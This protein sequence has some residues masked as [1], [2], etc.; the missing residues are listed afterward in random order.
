MVLEFREETLDISEISIE[1]LI[2]LSVEIE[3]IFFEFFL[4]N[5]SDFSNAI[6]QC[7]YLLLELLNLL[8]GAFE[9]SVDVAEDVLVLRVLLFIRFEF[10]EFLL[11]VRVLLRQVLHLLFAS[12]QSRHRLE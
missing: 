7:D 8:V 2:D 4:G 10:F 3:S 5:R 11:D 1:L 12:L 6:F 9:I